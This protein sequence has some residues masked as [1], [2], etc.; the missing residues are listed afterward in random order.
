LEKPFED[1][2]W[3]EELERL[4]PSGGK[5]SSLTLYWEQGYAWEPVNRWMI[6]QVIP[7]PSIPSGARELLEGPNPADH[8]HMEQDEY[9]QDRWVTHLPGVTR[10]QWHFFRKTGNYLRPYWVCQGAHGGHRLQFTFVERRII[11]MN[12]GDPNPPYPGQLP[13]AEPDART[14]SELGKRD[15][16]RNHAYAI[17]FMENAPERMDTDEKRG[18]EE[19]RKMVWDGISEQVGGYADEMAFHMNLDDAPTT[20]DDFVEKNELLKESFITQGA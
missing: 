18:L 19:M 12:G 15:L 3:T 13:F 5:L 1:P 16:L 11:D 14:F 7:G 8:G 20:K 6:G 2:K 9:G 10:R 17:D 4:S